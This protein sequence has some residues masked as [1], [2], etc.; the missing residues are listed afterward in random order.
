MALYDI[1]VEEVRGKKIEFK[2]ELGY[3]R[4]PKALKEN[5]IGSAGLDVYEEEEDYF[6]EDFSGINIDDDNLARL[7]TFNNVLVTSHQAFF[8]EEAM[9]NIAETTMEN[10]KQ[11][12]IN[13][14]FFQNEVCCKCDGS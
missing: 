6:F 7:L 4:C 13:N 12:S 9:G 1:S 2:T 14:L 10:I 5:N 3:S 8:T 11:F